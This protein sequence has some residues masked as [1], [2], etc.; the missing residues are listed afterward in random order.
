MNEEI[1]LQGDYNESA[2]E[3]EAPKLLSK[4]ELK[5]MKKQQEKEEFSWKK[6][7]ISW[8]KIIVFAIAM[9]LFINEFI[10][11]NANVPSGS[12]ENTI[13]PGDRMVGLRVSYWFN[14]PKRGDIVIFNN[15]EYVEGDSPEDSKFYVKRAIGLPGEKV[16]IKDAKVYINDSKEPLEEGYLKEEWYKNAGYD[17]GMDYN[18]GE[19]FFYVPKKGDKVTVKDGVKTLNG[20][21]IVL[22][23]TYMKCSDGTDINKKI[24]TDVTGEQTL[25]DGTYVVK[26][27]CYFMMGDNRNDS[28]DCRYWPGTNYVSDEDVLAKAVVGYLPWRGFYSHPSYE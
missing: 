16:K 20:N 21:V 4:K 5:K 8:I 3:Q 12:M 22:K 28:W 24:K 6:E 2:V 17:T 15:P 11:I 7:I 14:S 1:N 27:D 10:I 18:N 26:K 25:E 19:L 9:A 23:N 13:I